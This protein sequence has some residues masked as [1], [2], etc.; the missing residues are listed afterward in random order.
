VRRPFICIGG[1]SSTLCVW[2]VVKSLNA[3]PLFMQTV[4]RNFVKTEYVTGVWEALR[5]REVNYLY[6]SSYIWYYYFFI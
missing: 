1:S 6:F 2:Y 3:F 5:V 4:S